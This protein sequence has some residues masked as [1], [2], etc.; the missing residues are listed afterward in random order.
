[1]GKHSTDDNYDDTP[2]AA[3]FGSCG[4]WLFIISVMLVFGV[5]MVIMD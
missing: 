4:T 3:Y 2:M 5:L 1:M